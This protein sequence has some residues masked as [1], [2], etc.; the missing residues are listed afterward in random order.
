LLER[1][2]SGLGLRLDQDAKY[3]GLVAR[4]SGAG[5]ELFL[6][7]PQTYMNRSGQSV[8]PLARFYRIAPAEVLVVHDELDLLPGVARLKQGGGIA[9]HNGLRDIAAQFGVPDFWRLRLGIGHPGD[10]NRVAD[11]VLSSPPPG[12]REAIEAAIDRSLAVMPRIIAGDM[13]AAMLDLHGVAKSPKPVAKAPA[14]ASAK[15]SS[16]PKA[17]RSAPKGE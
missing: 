10:R 15:D 4:R 13:Q 1:L 8:V 16:I 7:L 17:A 5:N 9:G 11:W 12:D 6:V 3:K 14:G 2:A